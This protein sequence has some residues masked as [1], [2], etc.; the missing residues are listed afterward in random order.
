MEKQCISYH[1]HRRSCESQL[2]TL[3]HDI[4]SSLEN[5][6]QTDMVVLDFSKA[7]DHAHHQ[8]LMR[9][10][11]QYGIRGSTYHRISSFLFGRTQKVI[12]EGCSS[13]SVPVVSGVPQGSVLGPLLFLLFIN[14]LPD[15][16]VSNTRLF[17]GESMIA[18]YTYK[19]IGPK[20]VYHYKVTLLLRQ[21]GNLNGVWRF[22]PRSAAS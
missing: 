18:S 12:V 4:A 13:D 21:S 9:K 11:H 2:V 3:I 20:I 1:H 7:F 19:S 8:C 17:V 16:I 15:K 5:E 6:K 22:I 14:N 10:L